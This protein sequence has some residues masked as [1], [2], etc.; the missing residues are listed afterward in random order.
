[1]TTDL[2]ALPATVSF[3]IDAQLQ[4]FLQDSFYRRQAVVI[5]ASTVTQIDTPALL[6]IWKAVKWFREG[7][8]SISFANPSD[9]FLSAVRLAMH[10]VPGIF[11]E[12]FEPI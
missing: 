11:F 12:P 4:A 3:T 7:G 5:E 8:L 1:M 10:D 2:I 9:A 6:M